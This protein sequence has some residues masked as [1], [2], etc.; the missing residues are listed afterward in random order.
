MRRLWFVAFDSR[1]AGGHLWLLPGTVTGVFGARKQI[2]TQGLHTTANY[3][4][5]NS[6][7]NFK[8]SSRQ[9]YFIISIFQGRHPPYIKNGGM[10]DCS[11]NTT[12]ENIEI[13]C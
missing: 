11:Q 13:R 4:F 10:K 8:S 7:L 2:L 3:V 9:L 12:P 1:R 5:V 6:Y